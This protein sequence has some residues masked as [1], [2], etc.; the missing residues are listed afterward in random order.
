VE[1]EDKVA[2]RLGCD[3]AK[4]GVGHLTSE[5]KVLLLERFRTGWIVG[6]GIGST[7]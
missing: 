4:A 7:R 3:T 2:W 5:A 6:G 1:I